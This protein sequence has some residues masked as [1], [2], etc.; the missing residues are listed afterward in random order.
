MKNNKVVDIQ[1]QV[2]EISGSRILNLVQEDA[3]VDEHAKSY[4]GDHEAMQVPSLTEP[5]SG[6]K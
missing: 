3:I 2:H 5:K 4:V 6:S 1:D